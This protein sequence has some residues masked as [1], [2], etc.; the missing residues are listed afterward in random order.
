MII[1]FGLIN[2]LN[3]TNNLEIGVRSSCI[4]FE[5]IKFLFSVFMEFLLFLRFLVLFFAFINVISFSFMNAC[6]FYFL[7][8]KF[9]MFRNVKDKINFSFG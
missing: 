7:G 6:V 8:G 3:F 1:F 2:T 5:A 9:S 4:N